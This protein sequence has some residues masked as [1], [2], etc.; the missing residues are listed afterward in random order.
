MFVSYKKLDDVLL[1]LLELL[2]EVIFDDVDFFDI[3]IYQ[4]LYYLS[5]GK[6]WYI[7]PLIANKI[8]QINI[9]IC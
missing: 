1:I 3:D 4:L 5:N 2:S 9:K 8:L 7:D 6:I